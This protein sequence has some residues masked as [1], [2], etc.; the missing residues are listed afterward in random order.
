MTLR[1][2]FPALAFLVTLVAGAGA[3]FA[4]NT[5]F[6]DPVGQAD[7]MHQWAEYLFVGA[8]GDSVNQ[9]ALAGIGKMMLVINGA[10]LAVA[11]VLLAYN[12]IAGIAQSAHEGKILGKRW[13]SLW[14]PVRPV[15]GL[16]MLVPLPSGYAAVQVLVL[17]IAGLG[18][19]VA[20]TAWEAVVSGV[21]SGT[22]S[23][24]HPH[25]PEAR[26]TIE[27]LLRRE[28]CWQA[29]NRQMQMMVAAPDVRR[30]KVT[31]APAERRVSEKGIR[32]DYGPVCGTVTLSLP[33][34]TAPN[35]TIAVGIA[36]QIEELMRR[37]R[38]DARRL[39]YATMPG[40]GV[41]AAPNPPP[42]T[43]WMREYSQVVGQAVAAARD[44]QEVEA[45]RRFE[46]QAK[47]GGFVYA[48]SWY[49]TIANL[50][51]EFVQA[52]SLR[53]EFTGPN[54]Q[55]LP[56]L[57]GGL[58]VGTVMG[59]YEGWWRTYVEPA[60]NVEAEV[61]LGTQG[62][63]TWERLLSPGKWE[64]IY[65]QLDMT[66][67][68]PL[69]N[70][71]GINPLAELTGFGHKLLWTTE[72][73]L[74]AATANY[75]ALSSAAKATDAISKIPGV[76]WFSGTIGGATIG[77]MKGTFEFL[78]EFF[79][80]ILGGMFMAGAVLAYWL[81]M[82]PY[83]L[84]FIALLG[85]LTFLLEAV[86]ASTLWAFA[87]VRMDG[88][89][90]AGE[91]GKTGYEMVFN[92]LTRPLLMVVGLVMGYLV[93][94]VAAE[95]LSETF[96]AAMRGAMGSHIVGLVGLLVLTIMF[97]YLFFLAANKSFALIHALPDRV[98]IWAGAGR[99]VQP[100]GEDGDMNKGSQVVVGGVMQKAETSVGTSRYHSRMLGGKKP[101]GGEGGSSDKKGHDFSD[102]M[103]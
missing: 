92:L 30:S 81:P 84:W 29:V 23:I 11:S 76:G 49:H 25:V 12:V 98:A 83:V 45:R 69:D 87:H 24:T 75:A 3:A 62:D 71:G 68:T 27:E 19:S 91:A 37:M 74:I 10:L 63:S 51:T 42:V 56:T 34:S 20:N 60:V 2:I 43:T 32:W 40:T 64:W 9:P 58:E 38:L 78:K 17:T 57:G 15:I 103:P 79:F 89:G 36:G 18:W 35:R 88:E 46:E 86:V 82:I 73:V 6:F 16:A 94:F 39:A 80:F 93:F 66:N 8:I 96:Y 33:D 65:D 90:I 31:D 7:R 52:A 77:A 95:F 14:A 85:Y 99:G 48:G 26:G 1:M 5:G 41:D 22:A 70:T 72:G 97:V 4:Q 100:L 67:D 102:T 21:A 53:P 50:N 13:S 54:L 44:Q 55:R 59:A 28:V 61:A 47:Q 101:P